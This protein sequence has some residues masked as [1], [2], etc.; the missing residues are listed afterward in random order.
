MLALGRCRSGHRRQQRRPRHP[1]LRIGL[2]DLGNG[3]GDV[4]IENLRLLHQRGQ[5]RRPEAAPPIQRRHGRIGC[6]PRRLA[7]AR[8]NL[9]IEFGPFAAKDAAGQRRAE[10][11]HGESGGSTNFAARSCGQRIRPPRQPTHGTPVQAATLIESGLR[12][13]TTRKTPRSRH[14]TGLVAA[15]GLSSMR[16]LTSIR[17]AA[18]SLRARAGPRHRP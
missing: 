8:G 2:H 1:D 13:S 14:R 9:K 4:E 7:I 15:L 11:E 6:V 16:L 10:Q 17:P 18:G 5:L 12:A 3:D